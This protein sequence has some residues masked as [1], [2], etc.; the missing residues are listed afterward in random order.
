MAIGI[1]NF[2]TLYQTYYPDSQLPYLL[3]KN[4]P[5]LNMVLGGS[6]DGQVSGD[7]IDMPWLAGPATGVSQT[8]A[9]AQAMA[10]NA[11]Q[12]LRPQVRLSQLFKVIS[13]LDKDQIQSQGSASY[14]ELME[15][16]VRG[17]RMDILNKLDYLLHANGT[18]NRASFTFASA[19]PTVLSL[20]STPTGLTGDTFGIALGAPVAETLFEINDQVVITSTNRADGTAP[21]IVAGPV[22]VT[23]VTSLINPVGGQSQSI[24]VSASLAGSLTNSSV[25]GIALAG[26][27][28]GFSTA[29]LNPS[30]I[31]LDAFNPYGGP[32]SGESFLGVNRTVFPTR[33]AGNWI[34]GSNLNIEQA[35]KRSATMMAN[36][37][38]EPGGLVALMNPLDFDSLE[39]KLQSS[40]RYMATE[41]G[42]FF[43]DAIALNTA[44][45]KVSVVC[46]PH[47]QQ[48]F[49]RFVAPGALQLMYRNGL[50]HVATLT[51]GVNEQ[52]GA[53]YDGREQR[54]RSYAQMRC[55]DPRR[56]GIVKLPSVV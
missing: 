22:T 33:Y 8:F 54:L 40:A 15:V 52:W 55:V 25:Y 7:V 49:V 28:L 56:L 24:T 27:T 21:T 3:P 17:A 36:S 48:G 31:G 37:G 38:V 32:Q 35:L 51:G 46:D 18:G 16:T 44:M 4:L 11:P 20:N 43:F 53:N 34:N 13:I 5:L 50:P 14:G 23:A 39:A 12:S 6:T 26:D 41:L 19:T 45:G 30:I 29:L 1:S 47:V 9:T 2:E 10:G 42:V